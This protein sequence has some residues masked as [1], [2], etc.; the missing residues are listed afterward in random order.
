MSRH[1]SDNELEM[2][3]LTYANQVRKFR[4]RRSTEPVI[5]QVDLRP[6]VRCLDEL[7]RRRGGFR[8]KFR[9]SPLTEW[10]IKSK[11]GDVRY[12]DEP[13]GQGAIST[14][15][16]TARKALENI[17]ARWH[18][19]TQ[20]DGRVKITRM[21]DGSAHQSPKPRS[22]FVAVLAGMNLH[23]RVTLKSHYSDNRFPHMIKVLAR[24]EMGN[25]LANWKY[26]T[27]ARGLI[28]VT[29]IK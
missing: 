4:H 21:P 10:M 8:T 12:L 23:G 2:L 28:H 17:E 22:P 11:V 5:I 29:R 16:N 14:N 24:M 1:V 9:M 7:R 15:R 18:A 3:H 20:P 26:K 6:I 27:L 13:I 25:P 19:Q